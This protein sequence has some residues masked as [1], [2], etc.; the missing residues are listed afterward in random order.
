MDETSRK[1]P[2]S[3]KPGEINK[4]PE[5]LEAENE[6][7]RRRNAEL[8]GTIS[9]LIKQRD[10]LQEE[11]KHLK[12]PKWA[13]PNKKSATKKDL[14]KVGAKYGHKV[15]PRKPVKQEPDQEVVWVPELCGEGN[16]P[17][18]WPSKWHEHTQIDIPERQKFIVTKH[19][20]G[21]SYCAGCKKY[22]GAV[23]EKLSKSKYGPNLHAYVAY[24]KFD[25]GLTLGKIQRML[26]SQYDLLISTGVLSE[27]V[28]RCG[29]K[30]KSE[31]I[32]M[33]TNLTKTSHLHADETGWRNGGNSEWLWSFSN[34]KVSVYMIVPS[35]AQKVVKDVLGDAYGGILVSDFYGGYNK[36]SCRKQ[37]CWT[38][39]LRELHVLKER[40][41]ENREVEY[42]KVRLKRFFDRANRLK[43]EYLAG[44]DVDSQI[45]RLETNTIVFLTKTYAH[46]KLNTLVK[47]MTKYYFELYTFI[48]SNVPATNN[49][50]EREIRPAVLMRKTSYCNR[51]D[52]GKDT[53]AILMSLIA[54]SKKNNRNFISYASNRLINRFY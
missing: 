47:R 13:K 14:K 23:H 1:K 3:E 31:Y 46:K 34:D 8:E 45:K 21:W 36:I 6:K 53:Q 38:H 33:K 35:R 40:H 26:T 16:G 24:L 48:K 27:M 42:F 5:E 9:D 17:L 18:P 51:S 28:T 12:K 25:L 44:I 32:E 50:A 22:H 29:Q 37:K 54:T 7:L 39:L 43:V 20:V 11:I 15:N 10:Q 41:P 19:V 2:S 4:S 30:F 49:P 52:S